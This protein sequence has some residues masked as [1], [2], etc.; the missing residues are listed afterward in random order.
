[1]TFASSA[2]LVAQID[3]D[4]VQTLDIYKRFIP[5]SSALLG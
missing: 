3:R 5:E 2:E 4:V 1:M